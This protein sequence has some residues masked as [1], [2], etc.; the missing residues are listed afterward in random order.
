MDFQNRAGSA[1]GSGGMLST[2]ESNL[3]RRERLRRLATESTATDLSRDPYFMRNHLGTYECRLCLTVH[4]HEANYLTHT[5]GRKH[6]HNLA[7]R[8]ALMAQRQQQQQQLNE[9]S[10]EMSLSSTSTSSVQSKPL[11]A[12]EKKSQ[13]SSKYGIPK[14]SVR[15]IHTND[16]QQQQ[17]KMGIL[18]CVHYPDLYFHTAVAYS[19]TNDS[20]SLH[21]NDSVPYVGCKPVFRIVGAMEQSMDM[22]INPNYQYIVIAAPGYSNIAIKIPS[23]PIQLPST[24]KEGD[25]KDAND[26]NDDELSFEYWDDSSKLYLLQLIL[27]T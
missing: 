20:V 1:P 5:Q 13:P 17:Q 24:L 22:P 21:K 10:N 18:I 19:H 11:D 2:H 25:T 27:S 14:S 26:A 7:K 16:Q 4:T 23:I 3:L 12:T 8:A 9:E 6:Q 15:I